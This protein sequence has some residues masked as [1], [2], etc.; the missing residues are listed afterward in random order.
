MEHFVS[1]ADGV[2]SK[3]PLL[4]SLSTLLGKDIKLLW[5]AIDNLSNPNDR[6]FWELARVVFK[7]VGGVSVTSSVKVWSIY[8]FYIV[9][10][11]TILMIGQVYFCHYSTIPHIYQYNSRRKQCFNINR[12]N[13]IISLSSDIPLISFQG[14]YKVQALYFTC[15]V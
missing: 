14:V 5:N 11:L 7:P 15:P 8:W 4:D 10:F 13:Y 6:T 9:E 12:L 3:F 1:I 2:W